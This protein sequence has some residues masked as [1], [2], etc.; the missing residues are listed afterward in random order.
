[1]VKVPCVYIL[2]SRPYGTLYTGVTSNLVHRV[3][4]HK[5]KEIPGFTSKYNV[6][7]LVWY[8]V[9]ETMAT[10]IAR[11][12]QIKNWLRRWKIELVEAQNPR[13]DDLYP[14]IN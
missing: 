8:E 5:A 6:D 10:A 3:W 4:Q 11:E 14:A 9:H 2:A 13:W 7:R 1:M 12:K